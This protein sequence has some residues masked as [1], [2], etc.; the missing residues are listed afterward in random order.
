MAAYA[1]TGEDKINA[2]TCRYAQLDGREER[3]SFNFKQG[4][5]IGA[6]APIIDT[7]I[8]QVWYK[9]GRTLVLSASPN[10]SRRVKSESRLH[11]SDIASIDRSAR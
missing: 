10:L 3:R 4:S 9:D 8:W 1:H 7:H 11:Q 5:L 2:M 6:R